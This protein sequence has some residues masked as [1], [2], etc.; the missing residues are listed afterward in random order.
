MSIRAI[1]TAAAIALT[2]TPAY[3][4]THFDDISRVVQKYLDGTQHG[5]PALVEEAFLPSLEVQWLGEGDVLMRRPGPEYIARIEEGTEVMRHGRIV[6]IDATERSAMVKVEI[7]WNSRLYTD[8][9][10]MLKVEG[11]WRISN[12][13]A[14]WES[15]GTVD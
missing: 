11:E 15:I 1:L 4:D 12:K 10:L 2:F 13:I 5:R 7:E 6:S 8:Y 3:A 14:T 9:M